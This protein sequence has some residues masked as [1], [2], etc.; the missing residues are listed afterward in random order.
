MTQVTPIEINIAPRY[1][2]TGTKLTGYLIED[3]L[4]PQEFKSLL[5][6]WEQYHVQGIDWDK[7]VYY[8]KG[9]RYATANQRSFA[10]VYDRKIFDLP[11][12]S[13][14]Y[15]QTK[16]TIYDW[17]RERLGRTIHPR[18]I[19][20]VEKLKTLPPFNTNPEQWIPIRS[21]INV[22]SYQK[23][24]E[25][26]LDTDSTIYNTTINDVDQYS[27]TIYLNSVSDGGEF[28]IDGEPGFVYKPKPNSAFV[29]NGGAAI[30]G[31]SMNL[32]KD[33]NI[34]KALTIRMVNINSLLLPGHPDKFLFKT[35]SIDEVIK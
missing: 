32:D 10:D 29:F 4:T 1:E 34:R 28:W 31:V 7:T 5:S 20:I 18:I 16:D 24:L 23:M 14:W 11:E 2:I 26:H 17:A 25:F 8:F 27:V 12:H 21:L 33:K 9:K 13:E 22:L 19:Q 6:Y 30:H 15:Y 35:Y 3:F